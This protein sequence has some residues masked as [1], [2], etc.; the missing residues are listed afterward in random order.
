MGLAQNKN[1]SID[2]SQHFIIPKK[3]V[4]IA[5]LATNMVDLN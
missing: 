5:Q 1:I 2:N 4:I 3:V